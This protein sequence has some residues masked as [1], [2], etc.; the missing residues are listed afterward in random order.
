MAPDECLFQTVFMNSPYREKRQ[1]NLTFLEWYDNNHPR[2]FVESDFSLLKSSNC[3]FARKF[4]LDV[5]RKIIELL[6]SDI[7]KDK[8]QKI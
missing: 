5:D 4:D 8:A 1:G 7:V 3:L 2:T 6:K